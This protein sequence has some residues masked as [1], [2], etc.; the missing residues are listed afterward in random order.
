M[1]EQSFIFD[2]RLGHIP[3]TWRD[4]IGK[5]LTNRRINQLIREGY[6]GPTMKLPPPTRGKCLGCGGFSGTKYVTYNYLPSWGIWCPGCI[7]KI[8]R[9]IELEKELNRRIREAR[10]VE[11][12]I[13]KWEDN[14]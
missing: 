13:T 6:Y 1:S 2:L 9:E 5:L 12:D 3:S 14:D 8:R 10:K 11:F 7:D 4:P